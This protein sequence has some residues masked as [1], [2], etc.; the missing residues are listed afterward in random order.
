VSTAQAQL[1]NAAEWIA[2]GAD[3]ESAAPVLSAAAVI[4]ARHDNALRAATLWAATDHA[5]GRINRADTPGAA[6]L[7][8]DWLPLAR[9]A[10]PD[11]ATWE[12]AWA[13]GTALSLDEALE[14]AVNSQDQ[15]A[16]PRMVGS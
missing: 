10:A 13:A 8:N 6:K 9:T 15:A 4:A 1:A 14:L 5:L 11:S 3:P 7:R 16:R 12:A 2:A